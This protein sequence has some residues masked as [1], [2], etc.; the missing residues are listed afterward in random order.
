MPTLPSLDV[1][2]AQA[3]RMMAAFGALDAT[4][5]PQENYLAWLKH[6]IID[7][8]LDFERQ[9][10][11][12]QFRVGETTADSTARAALGDDRVLGE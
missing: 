2:S 9:Q 1:T 11:L 12:V 7:E 5:T 10:R 8:V 4:K 3:Q 6:R